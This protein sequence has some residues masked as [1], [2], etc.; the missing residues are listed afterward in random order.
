MGIDYSGRMV[1]AARKRPILQQF[2]HAQFKEMD[3]RFMQALPD[4]YYDF[5]L[6]S[7]NGLDYVSHEDRKIAI[8]EIKRVGKPG[9]IFVF[10]S[11]NLYY[12][13]KMYS[14]TVYRNPRK[15]TYQFYRYAKLLQYNGSA[16][17]YMKK[18]YAIV[19]DGSERFG[20]KTYYI[21]PEEQIRILQRSGFRNIRC[22][23]SKFGNR[24]AGLKIEE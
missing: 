20:L 1:A 12:L 22:F 13:N 15:L 21:K 8:E 24:T 6:F 2:K 17:K 4:N 10:S 23:S 16:K 14:I 9:S 7:Y 19:N 11:H 18:P 3:V 5:I